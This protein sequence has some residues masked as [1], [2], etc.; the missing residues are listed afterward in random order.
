MF[1]SGHEKTPGTIAIKGV[2][3]SAAC[4]LLLSLLFLFSTGLYSS[5]VDA[6]LAG[7]Q[8]KYSSVK[9]ISGSFQL[10]GKE[11]GIEQTDTGAFWLKKP[12]CIRWDHQYPEE[13]YFI[14]DGKEFFTYI[15]QDNQV[16]IQPL[17]AD[18]MKNS[19]LHILLGTEDIKN[20]YFIS[21][22]DEYVP[23]IEGTRIIRLTPKGVEPYYSYLVLEI[24]PKS[25]NLQ[26]LVM[27]E[28]TGNVL[29]Y[30]F[31][32]LTFDVNV[33]NKKF[34]FKIPDDVDVLQIENEP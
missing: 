29:E 7:M 21:P 9:T 12:D 17:T 2:R 27:R 23:K 24:D 34:K 15:P 28:R 30:I 5:D 32:D 10:Y 20:S 1:K 14:A 22:E 18:D 26:R 33:S 3:V 25:F 16:T 31:S 13:K 8:Q 4:G 19:P 11:Q 6:V